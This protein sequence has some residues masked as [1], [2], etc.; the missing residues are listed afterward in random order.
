MSFLFKPQRHTESS[1]IKSLS[2]S[3]LH[4]ALFDYGVERM[5][6]VALQPP[7]MGG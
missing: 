1:R 2:G 6:G 5:T 4:M 3:S 7:L